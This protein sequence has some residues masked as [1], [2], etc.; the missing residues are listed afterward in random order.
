MGLTRALLEASLVGT[1][2]SAT[3]FAWG[4]PLSGGW[5]DVLFA[6]A[7]AI[8]LS[9]CCVVSFYY[10]DLY[11]L[12]IVPSFGD[13]ASRL[14]QAIGVALILLS[15]CYAFLPEVK[16]PTGALLLSI[17]AIL[18]VLLPIRALSYRLLRRGP[19][20]ERVLIVGRDPMAAK[21]LREIES[22]PYLGYEVVG[23]ADDGHN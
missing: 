2:V 22:R 23:V 19:F 15:A 17:L 21:I 5:A 10:H 11:D 13:F 16:V 20:L 3:I 18:G 6:L 4:Q 1:S 8:T 7:Q 12:R 14:L 9:F